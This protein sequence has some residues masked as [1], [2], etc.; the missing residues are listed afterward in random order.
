MADS[1]TKQR[2]GFGRVLGRSATGAINVAVGGAAVIAA[3]AIHSGAL[4]FL[5]VSAYVALVAFDLINPRFWQKALSAP[6]SQAAA[7]PAPN[8]I[9]DEAVRQ[10][11]RGILEARAELGRVLGETPD[12]VK[13]YLAAALASVSD[14]ETRAGHL[15]GRAETL[16]RYLNNTKPEAVPGEISR[17]SDRAHKAGDAQ[18]K[19][20]YQSAQRLREEQLRALDDLAVARDRILANLARIAATLEG[21]PPRVVRMRAL[22]AQAVDHLSGDLNQELDE[23]SGEIKGFEET[24]KLL[25]EVP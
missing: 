16:S 19:N 10:A 25:A 18:A 14:L 24:L 6:P 17:L 23:M 11:V 8:Q 21:L 22:D 15:A 1:R 5:G 4:L 7:L 3:A 13:S 2:P 20:E 12:D 9:T